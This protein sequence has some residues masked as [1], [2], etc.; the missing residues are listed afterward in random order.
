MHFGCKRTASRTPN[1]QTGFSGG[2]V[3]SNVAKGN[4]VHHLPIAAHA[5]W[6]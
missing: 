5:S 6:D 4:S 3:A 2:I 1:G